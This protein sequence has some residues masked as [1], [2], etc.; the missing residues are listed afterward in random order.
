MPGQT[1][2]A[3][4]EDFIRQVFEENFEALRLES[5]HTIAPDTKAAALNQVLLYWRKLR[6]IA[7]RIT[8]T[9]VHLSL[10]QQTTP[11][12]R[13]YT[14]EGVVDIVRE[15]ERVIMYDIKTHDADFVR[16]NLDL[17]AQQLNVYAHIWQ[18]LRRQRL[19]ETAVIA[20]DYPDAVKRAL[21]NP[22]PEALAYALERWNPV[23]PIHYDP[24]AKD[25]TLYEFGQVVDQIEEG[26]FAPPPV[27]RLQEALPGARQE[28]FA[29]RVCRDCDARF[30]CDSYRTYAQG[31][32]RIAEQRM[33]IYFIEDDPDREAWRTASLDAAREE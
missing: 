18:E 14:I 2:Y 1:D 27:E 15:D 20:T 23:V 5:G 21:D 24:A 9:E 31:S 7:E 11:A 12:G 33:N 6:D 17:Y 3:D 32:P 30:S 13:E 4:I 16:A 22:D 8:D 10:P 28:R 29:V 26:R 19:D 25:R